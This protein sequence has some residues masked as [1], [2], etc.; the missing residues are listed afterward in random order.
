MR[1]L[2]KENATLYLAAGGEYVITRILSYI[3]VQRIK[4]NSSAGTN[5]LLIGSEKIVK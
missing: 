2:W 3:L 1:T 5:H 4:S